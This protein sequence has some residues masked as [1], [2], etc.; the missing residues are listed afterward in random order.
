M[1]VAPGPT[2]YLCTDVWGLEASFGHGPRGCWRRDAFDLAS[3][4][5]PTSLDAAR[6]ARE[7]RCP[8]LALLML[9][10]RAVRKHEYLFRLCSG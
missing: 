6:L 3:Q 4:G 1:R 5:A 2:A 9:R 7:I 8:G 10:G